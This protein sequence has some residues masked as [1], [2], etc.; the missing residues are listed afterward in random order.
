MPVTFEWFGDEAKEK[1]KDA[2][3]EALRAGAEFY[4]DA[5]KEILS[6]VDD[7][8]PSYPGEPPHMQSLVAEL[9]GVTPLADTVEVYEQ[10][11]GLEI[12]VGSS[13]PYAIL[14]ELGTQWIDPRPAWDATA[15]EK[16]DQI[17]EVAQKRFEAVVQATSNAKD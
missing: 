6:S 2:A 17:G 5:M 7:G 1:L 9:R 8:G 14:L 15:Q 4:R 16:A 11:G 3:R 12:G 13:S 10:E